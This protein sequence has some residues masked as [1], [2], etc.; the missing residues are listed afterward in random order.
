MWSRTLLCCL[1]WAGSYAVHAQDLPDGFV[2]EVMAGGFEEAVGATFDGNGRAYVWEKRG[3]VWIVDNGTRL[4]DPLIDLSEEVGDWRDHGLLGFALDPQ[5]LQNGRIYLMYLVDRHHLQFFGT[6]EYDPGAN[7]HF[8]ASIIRITRYSAIGPDFTTVDAQSRFVLL[9]ESAST[10]APVTHESHSSGTLLFGEDGTLLASLGDGASYSGLDAGGSAQSWWAQ[11]LDDGMMRPEENVGAFRA[12]MVNS[13][14]GKVLRLDPTTGD[15][16]PSNPWFDAADP[17]APRSRVWAMGLRNPYRM[18]LRPGT[19]SPDPSVG[20]PG[21]LIIGDVGWVSW[22]EIN[23]CDRGG[24]NFGWPLFEGYEPSAPYQATGTLNRDAPNPQFPQGGC[25]LPYLRFMDLLVQETPQHFGAHRNPCDATQGIPLGIP[26]HF[27]TRPAVD[28]FHGNRSRTGGFNGA[29]AITFDLDDPASPVPGPRFGGFCAIAGPQLTGA[30]WPQGFQGTTIQADYAGTW[31]RLFDFDAQDRPLRVRNFCSGRGAIV[32]MDEGPDGWLW[33][34]RFNSGQLR[35]IRYT[36]PVDLP[37][38]AVASAEPLFGPG[39]LLVQFSS[40][41][42][43]DPEGGPLSYLWDFDN[44]F[45]S[46]LPNPARLFSP[47]GGAMVVY[48]VT[49]TVTDATGASHTDTVRI[50][51]NNTPPQV[52]ITSFPDGALYPVGVGTIFALEAEVSDAEHGPEALSYLW[53]TYMDAGGQR[54][55]VAVS[56]EPAAT[57]LIGGVGCYATDYSWVVELTVTDA[58]GLSTTVT[59]RLYPDCDGVA[60]T[61]VILASAVAGKGPLNVQLDGTASFDPG[62]IVA[63]HWNFGDGS[64]STDPAPEK[65]FEQTGPYHVVLTVTDDSGLTGQA[66]RVITVLT[67]Q[68]PQCAGPVGSVRR[69]Y[70]AGITGGTVAQLLAAP[71][72]PANP[73][74][75]NF[76]ATFQGPVNLANNYGTRMRAYLVPPETGAYRFTVVSDDNSA[77]FLSPYTDPVFK[78]E[79]CNVP[80]WTNQNQFDKYPAQTSD[81]IELVAGRFYYLEVLHKEDVG[82]DHVALF[83]R[84][85]SNEQP[86]LIPGAALRRWEDCP[87][88]VSVRMALQG[89]MDPVSGLMRDDLRAAGLL[90][91]EEPYTALGFPMLGGSGEQ[92]TAEQLAVS[93]K[94]AVVDWVLV[95]LRDALDPAQIVASQPALLERD[96]DVMGTDGYLR[97]N[98]AVPPGNYHVAVRHRNHLGIRTAQ[99]V[100]LGSGATMVDFTRPNTPVHGLDATAFTPAGSRVLWAGDAR[101]DG[102]LKYTGAGND[103]DAV[104][105]VIGGNDP[106][107]TVSG[108]HQADTNM[109]GVVKYTGVGNDRDVILQNIGGSVPTAV[110]A[111]QWP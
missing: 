97:L 79:I 7:D 103:R 76:P 104:L 35:R 17:R 109:D 93:G 59:H 85:P 64:I 95:D 11:A 80:G 8:K 62:S 56:T 111:A 23:V 101:A 19:G 81:S 39:P 58:A 14:S 51:L 33:Y 73:T 91:L 92:T 48:N 44:G 63:Y 61:A 3:I 49:L 31:M 15:G 18:T 83:W 42:S 77:V 38:T 28:W 65:V 30:G 106:V 46:T 24:L 107:Q 16:V 50:H 94:N 12:Q 9:G 102:L 53:R 90:P 110:R 25:T 13:F 34:M 105:L 75:V 27:H 72:F 45:T 78:Q 74:S 67:D 100:Q 5:F 52:A 6:P 32:W 43:V 66:V 98:F 40:A 87:T 88:G 36:L 60:P 29:E 20:R 89:C 71:N 26:Q 70:Y 108:Y 57:T 22:E 82:G 69:E 4:P 41:G 96:G 54:Y 84:T 47:A 55:L 10:G 86:V 37:P 21:T 68:P 1:V 99:P 2:D